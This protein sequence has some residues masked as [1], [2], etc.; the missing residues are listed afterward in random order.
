[1]S[2]EHQIC[3]FITGGI[4]DFIASL[5]ALHVIRQGFRN[6]R[7]LLVGN[8]LWLPLARAGTLV[9][10]VRSVDDLPLHAGFTNDLSRDHPLSR[11]FAAFDLIISWFG[12]REGRWEKTLRGACAGRL[13]VHPYHRV[14]AFEGHVSD[15][16]LATLK[17]LGLCVHDGIGQGQPPSPLLLD[18]VFP[19]SHPSRDDQ[20]EVG[21][22]LCLHPGSGSDRKNWPKENFLEVADGAFRRWR[23]P[24][25]VL[26]GPAEQGQ[27]AFWNEAGGPSLSVKEGL[28]ILEV[29]LMLRRA[30]LYVGNDS[31]ITHHTT[32]RGR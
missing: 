14:H 32:Q 15:F 29:A 18:T 9:D 27:R 25:T 26:T 5:P 10:E 30:A 8:P 22:F 2:S 13:L 6:S 23:L 4:G 1:M 17:E 11:F 20:A 19:A 7:I 16:Y 12:D 24:S 21:A 28:P 31:G 3:I